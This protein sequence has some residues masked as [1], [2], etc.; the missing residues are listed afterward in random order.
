MAAGK[1]YRYKKKKKTYKRRKRLL[2]LM[3]SPVPKMMMT[4]FRYSDTVSINPSAAGSVAEHVFVANGM[5][6]PD[7][8]GVGHQPR[9]F[10][11]FI[12]VLYD[13]YVVVGAK[14]TAIL[15]NSSNSSPAYLLLKA[16]DSS[17][18]TIS[19]TD[20]FED[21]FTKY[22]VAGCGA[23]GRPTAQSSIQCNIGKYLG[24]SK[25]LSDPHLKGDA[26]SN[27]SEKVWFHVGACSVDNSLDLNAVYVTVVIEY[28]CALIERRNPTES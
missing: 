5:Y 23:T 6:D 17:Q 2:N 16:Q 9:G 10:D 13:H 14:I 18:T 19:R 24:R 1:I 7:A 12:G 4:K 8:T 28:I 22:A 26:T 11:Q 21:A 20:W 25:P 27:P 15:D 3:K